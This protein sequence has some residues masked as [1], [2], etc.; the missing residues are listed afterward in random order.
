MNVRLALVSAP[1]SLSDRYG[2]F[3]GAASTQPS[4]GLACLAGAGLEAGA[5]VA[6]IEASAENL[7]VDE[8][9]ARVRDFRPHVLGISATTSGIH[10]AAALADAVKNIDPATV[11]V[12]G[13]PHITALP[14]RTLRLFAGFDLGVLGEGE[15]TLVEILELVSGEKRV[16]RGVAGTAGR[17]GAEIVI[18]DRR[19]FMEDL[20]ELPLPA[21]SLF[22]GFPRSFRPSPG[23]I[24]RW[25][26]A[27]IV[28]T[29]GCPNK[30]T[31]CDRSVFG[32]KCRAYSPARAVE[33]IDD[34]ARNHG[35]REILIEDDTFVISK[36]RVEDFC[37]RL[38]DGKADISWSCLGRADCV[39]PDILRLMRQAGC[40]HI[41]YGIESGDPAIL[42]GVN[43]DL[44]I[45]QITQALRWSRAAGMRTKGFF[46]VGFP[47]ETRDSLEATRRLV[48]SLP[49]DD[50]SVM[51]L[52]PFPGS[53]LY[54]AAGELG[55]FDD[56]WE[57]MNTLNT[58]F[59]PTGLTV[60]DLENARRA[61]LKSFYLRVSVLWRHALMF[62]RRPG[63][64]RHAL[65][66]FMV[67]VRVL[68]G[69]S[70]KGG[71]D[72]R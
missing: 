58:I 27:S 15:R 16:P 46:M 6:V 43:K 41:S 45:D 39:D 50:V 37:R 54:G 48:R 68:A 71:R 40:W 7:S 60:A 19:P 33:I 35:V 55:E 42:E 2:V 69:R 8:T 70:R 5:E 10:G 14:E 47:G 49:L 52:T 51:Q 1:V 44:D 30:C 21:W 23:R 9:T 56:D 67:L 64:F 17:D 61:I 38:I 28:L 59:V 66:A 22:R 65:P 25:P 4:F 53:E 18:N 72:E 34:L 57:K 31:F 3:E 26:C 63:L 11:V 13:G 62:V 20:D 36:G 12:V 29:R 24:R 32:R